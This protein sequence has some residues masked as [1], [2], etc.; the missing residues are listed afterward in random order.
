MKIQPQDIEIEKAVIGAMLI[1][2]RAI[3]EATNI[4][5]DSSCFYDKKHQIIFDAIKKLK[6]ESKPVDILTVQDE[7]DAN[8]IPPEYLI[9]LSMQVATGAHT[10]YHSRIIMDLHIKRKLI[11]IAGKIIEQAYN[12]DTDVIEIKN[13]LNRELISIDSELISDVRIKGFDEL[14]S[15]ITDKLEVLSNLEAGEITG[16]DTG[17][18]ALNKYNNGWQVGTL[19]IIAARPSMGKTALAIKTLL[20]NAKRNIPV[21]LFSLETTAIKITERAAAIETNFDLY[22]FIKNGINDENKFREWKI[23][24]SR[25]SRFP[26]YI[27]DT[28]YLTIDLLKQRMIRMIR[29]Y[30]VKLIAIDYL[31]LISMPK[32]YKGS[33]EQFVSQISRE[34]KVFS[35]EY[36]VP[37]IALSQL[38]RSVEQRADKRPQLSDLR[39]SGAIEQD[40]DIVAFLYRPEY[41]G[42]DT[43]PELEA[44]YHNYNTEIIIAKNKDGQV[45]SLGLNFDGSHVRFSDVE[46]NQ[47]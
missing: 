31:Q 42:L 24:Q 30:D 7:L 37:I 25:L 14:L 3:Y 47:F 2:S 33:R 35:K 29:D 16:I 11:A 13:D 18:E 43:M 4:I 21:A 23:E 22:T 45:G 17:F 8:I 39:E 28:A 40:A 27:D 15:K 10:A 34:L 6:A 46:V 12:N 19:N 38:S 20:E 44:D 32:N 1:D 9:T 5:P 41:Y 26:F 36:E